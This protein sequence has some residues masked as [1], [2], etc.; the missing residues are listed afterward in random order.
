MQIEMDLTAGIDVA[1]VVLADV[2]R[3]RNGTI[4]ADEAQAYAGAVCKAI[5]LELDG[6]PLSVALLDTRF[7]GLDAMKHG[8]GAIRIE[9]AAVMSPV[10]A[11]THHLRFRNSHRPD[12]SVYLANVLVP[13]SDLVTVSGQRR[14]VDQRELI[15]DYVLRDDPT[16][17]A[18]RWLIAGSAG[19]V[20]LC[21]AVWWRRSRS[22]SDARRG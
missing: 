1:D 9:L 22:T 7:P 8:E 2:D 3:D 5:S 6:T 14:D 10:P 17:E 13:A 11:G 18:R 4:S 20:V 16:A 12:I 15:V 21:V 19:A